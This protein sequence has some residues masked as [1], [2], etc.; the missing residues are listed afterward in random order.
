MCVTRALALAAALAAVVALAAAPAASA[1]DCGALPTL[2]D[3]DGRDWTADLD[4][5]ID[6][7]DHDS[8]N[9]SG[10]AYFDRDYT[11]Y[12][13]W[14]A[15][16]DFCGSEDGGREIVFP[17]LDEGG[18][19]I[20]PKVY[21]PD[22]A[23]AFVRHLWRF[24]NTTPHPRRL[25]MH[26]W[27][28]A[29]YATTDYLTTSSGDVAVTPADDWLTFQNTADP[30]DPRVAL[31]WQGAGSRRTSVEALF[32]DC[33]S[34]DPP[35]ITDTRDRPNWRYTEMVLA[36]GETA[37]IVTFI[38]V[39]GSPDEA[40]DAAAA[41]VTAPPAAFAGM[42][43]DELRAVRNF[44]LPDHD[45]DGRAN[46]ADVCV[47]VPDPEQANA[48][49][50][51][52]GDACDADDDNDGAADAFE[53]ELRTDPRKAD[54]DGDGRNDGADACPRSRG[55]GADGCP[56]GSGPGAD[57]TVFGRMTPKAVS[58]SLRRRGRRLAAAGS[59]QPPDVLDRAPA[60]GDRG[61]V[62]LR[63]RRGKRTVA[64]RRARLRPDCTYSVSAR[65]RGRGRMSARVRWLGNDF[66][67]PRTIRT[68]NVRMRGAA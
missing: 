27:N 42:S 59:V 50:D 16:G 14:S 52:E 4:A 41:M 22:G 24:D 51:A 15:A 26:S 23:P 40:R 36:P 31:V 53:A 48:D 65:V 6:S 17:A 60:C 13:F 37:V 10:A 32:N 34:A 25:Q 9:N 62:E 55:S 3:A 56:S 18:L 19:R 39:R 44:T 35:P 1:L 30:T 57:G 2:V 38:L 68:R 7:A 66:L 43:E 63:V 11:H 54:T 8:V 21:V 58:A 67:E 33:C 20:A 47:F 61:F 45:R 46:E 64:R 28:V 12:Y 29:D 5:D 49:G